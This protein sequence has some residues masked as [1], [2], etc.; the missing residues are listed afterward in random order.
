MENKVGMFVEAKVLADIKKTLSV[1]NTPNDTTG[2]SSWTKT[3]IIFY[4]I[5][6]SK[7]HLKVTNCWMLLVT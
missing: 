3:L 7:Q 5:N 1:Q 2:F 4:Q 6:Q